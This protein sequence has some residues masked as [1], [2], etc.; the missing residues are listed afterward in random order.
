MAPGPD[1]SDELSMLDGDD[2]AYFLKI[3]VTDYALHLFGAFVI[4]AQ[5][6]TLKVAIELL[7]IFISFIYIN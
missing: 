5:W 6:H 4:K 3:R 1:Q 2:E 7:T